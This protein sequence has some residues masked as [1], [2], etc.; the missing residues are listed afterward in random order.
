M[1]VW[2]SKGDFSFLS[3][4]VCVCLEIMTPK[5]KQD[6]VRRITERA[7]EFMESSSKR[8]EKKKKKRERVENERTTE[9]KSEGGSRERRK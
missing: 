5:G 3:M 9:R 4:R 1:A 7:R 2:W 6:Y 8:K